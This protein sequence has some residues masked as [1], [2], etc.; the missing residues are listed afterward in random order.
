MKEH[1]RTSVSNTTAA[2]SDLYRHLEY[3][4]DNRKNS[5]AVV[6][7]RPEAADRVVKTFPRSQMADAEKYAESLRPSRITDVRKP[8]MEVVRWYAVID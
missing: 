6:I 1:G 4:R 8:D 5:L 3:I 2:T 7:S